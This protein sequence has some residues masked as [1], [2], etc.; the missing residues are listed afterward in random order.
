MPA[1][2]RTRGYVSRFS[3]AYIWKA[4][5]TCLLLLMH[6][7]WSAFALARARAGKSKAAKMAMMAITTRSSISVKA[8]V[9]F[10]LRFMSI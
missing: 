5:M 3:S 10:S 8:R 1:N 6:L 7:T 9:C 2:L 4:R